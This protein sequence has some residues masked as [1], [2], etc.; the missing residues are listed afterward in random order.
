MQYTYTYRAL[1][2][3]LKNDKRNSLTQ[4]SRFILRSNAVHTLNSRKHLKV[5]QKNQIQN[6]SRNSRFEILYLFFFVPY[7]WHTCT[8][9]IKR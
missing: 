4:F 7:F 3:S 8:H 5:K 9:T 2:R 6:Y 1:Q